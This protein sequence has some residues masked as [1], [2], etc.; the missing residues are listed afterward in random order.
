[1]LAEHLK[2]LAAE[3]GA[4]VLLS[5]HTSKHAA[6][7]LEQGAARGSGALTAAA[8][9]VANLARVDGMAQTLGVEPEDCHKFLRFGISKNSYGSRAHGSK[10]FERD[11]AGVLHDADPGAQRR[12]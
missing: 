7:S 5:H 2:A 8:R 12:G 10:I 4:A 1:R 3:S 9:W 6:L 11:A